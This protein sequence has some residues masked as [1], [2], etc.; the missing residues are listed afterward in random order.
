MLY[1]IWKQREPINSNW[2]KRK[3][4]FDYLSK[5]MQVGSVIV[6]TEI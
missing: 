1:N 6:V 4:K 5:K 3:K 2:T